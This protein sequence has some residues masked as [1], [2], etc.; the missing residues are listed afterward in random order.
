[1]PRPKVISIITAKSS[2]RPTDNIITPFFQNTNTVDKTADIIE[3]I[4]DELIASFFQNTNTVDKTAEI[5]SFGPD[6]LTAPFYSNTNTVDKSATI[7]DFIV[8]GG[9][10]WRVNL[11]VSYQT[12]TTA[13]EI[14]ELAFLDGAGDPIALSGA[15]VSSKTLN[16]ENAFD[17][18][19]ST[20][21]TGDAGSGQDNWIGWN[22]D[23]FPD[24][25]GIRLA[26]RTGAASGAIRRKLI[27]EKSTDNGATYAPVWTAGESVLNAL[28]G[29]ETLDISFN[30][31]PGAMRVTQMAVEIAYSGAP[32]A[33]VTQMAVEVSSI[34]PPVQFTP[35]PEDPDLITTPPA[36][37][38][39]QWNATD[40]DMGTGIDHDLSFAGY[41]KST[42]TGTSDP[43]SI[44]A[45]NPIYGKKVWCVIA[46]SGQS[47]CLIGLGQKI[48][49]V[50]VANA[51]GETADS[52]GIRNDQH[53]RTNNADLDTS[54]FPINSSDA[55][56]VAFDADTRKVW[57]GRQSGGSGSIAWEGNPAAGTGAQAT[58]PAGYYYPMCT[59]VDGN[60][61]LAIFDGKPRAT[62]PSSTY[63]PPAAPA[64]FSYFDVGV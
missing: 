21:W 19:S 7:A 53:L 15:A 17:G 54:L 58:M 40:S 12:Q 52:I 41:V 10:L 25:Q 44:R 23:S 63:T 9:D 4:P 50:N 56:F 29:G 26:M 20:Y 28:D 6:E 13:P 22:F 16:M 2:R 14:A 32:K 57:F 30:D 18:D 37:L 27:V 38:V 62:G 55:I 11:L 49:G 60:I 42:T 51:I 47:G 59:V 61:Q 35:E 36:T 43:K 34:W 48:S 1:M 3:F 39:Q 8:S 5:E 24:V 33:R 46:L 64:G 45:R 31:T